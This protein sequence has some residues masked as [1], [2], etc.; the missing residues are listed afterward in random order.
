MNKPIRYSQEKI[1]RIVAPASPVKKEFLDKGISRIESFFPEIEY[2]EIVFSK[3]FFLAGRDEDRAREL[4]YSINNY[5][6]LWSARG[7]YGSIRLLNRISLKR[8]KY[9]IIIGSSD[10]TSLLLCL[11][12]KYNFITFYGPM[13]AGEIA[14]F[15]REFDFS[16]LKGVLTGELEEGTILYDKKLE[17][18][19]AGD[20]EGEITGGCL[21]LVV[22]TLGTPFEIDT[23]NKI[24]FLED[25][26]TKPYEIDRML[27][28]LKY[29]GKLDD[30]KGL[31]FGEM[32]NCVQ[33]KNQ[34]YTLQELIYEE[35]KSLKKPVYFGLPCGHTKNGGTFLPIGGRVK[36]I[37]GKIY[38]NERVVC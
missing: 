16:L 31:I 12:Q 24:L 21:S 10:V 27:T 22:S 20:F 17:E 6:F 25:V 1:I 23:K 38:L 9:P 28:Q 11:T 34:G 35:L 18:I 29:S 7:G 30:C 36:I 8:E 33:N 19:I 32:V 3:Y 5:D 13:V 26:N 2:G 14:D 37:D 15:S 4:N